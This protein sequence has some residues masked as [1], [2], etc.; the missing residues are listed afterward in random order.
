MRARCKCGFTLLEILV[1]IG[2]LYAICAYLLSL[3][4]SGWRFSERNREHTVAVY[5]AR[6]KMENLSCAPVELLGKS[7]GGYC[8]EPYGD[9][10]WKAS[11][12]DFKGE[13]RLLTLEIISPCRA[14]A[15]LKRLLRGRSFLGVSCDSYSDQL[16]WAGPESSAVT[17]NQSLGNT[18]RKINLASNGI[19]G[20]IGSICGVPGRGVVW[21]CYIDKPVISYHS[22]DDNGALSGSRILKASESKGLS[23]PLFTGIAG[24][25]WGNLLYCADVVNGGIWIAEDGLSDKKLRWKS[26]PLFPSKLPL[27]EPM[28]LALDEQSSILWIAEGKCSAVRPLSLRP[29][30]RLSGEYAEQ[31]PDG[32]WWG[33][34]YKVPNGTGTLN[35][36]AV[37]AWSSIVYTVDSS[38]LHLMA[39]SQSSAGTISSSWQKYP[40]PARLCELSPSGLACD[41]YRNVVYINT[42]K[43]Q[44]WQC[45]LSGT[46]T[47]KEIS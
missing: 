12:S 40:L 4:A 9:Y 23:P 24:D 15:V 35:G 6:N 27:E 45:S 29:S 32:C 47:F 37:N 43:G 31:L 16:L 39:Y 42:R 30:V 1:S 7:S 36:I 26:S 3:F 21:S 25:C 5:L 22:F 14:R 28:G 19:T 11:V 44:L 38:Y 8:P 2:I 33:T 20:Y 13:L 17:V 46:V 18:K 41:P 34:R 10:A